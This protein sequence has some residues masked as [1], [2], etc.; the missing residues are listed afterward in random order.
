MGK[1]ILKWLGIALGGVL[2]LILLAFIVSYVAV[3]RFLDKEHD[4][5]SHSIAVPTD[6]ALIAEGERLANFRGCYGACHGDE[7]EGEVM[8]DAPFIARVVVPSLSHL[9]R[10][11]TTAEFERAVRHGVKGDGTSVLIMPSST[12]QHLSDDDLGATIAFLRSLPA[13]DGPLTEVKPR[14]V[15]YFLFAFGLFQGFRAPAEEIDHAAPHTAANPTDTLALGR[16][17]AMSVCSLCHGS[18]LQG[19]EGEKG[20]TPS[21]SI[22]AAYTLDGFTQV[23]REGIGLGGREL[24]EMLEASEGFKHFTDHEIAALYAYLST[25]AQQE[26]V[27]AGTSE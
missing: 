7:A 5:P 1:R 9:A 19:G 26:P 16:Y 23:L 12:F 2:V 3:R 18:D 27:D 13:D 25:L 20:P 10:E 21:L 22:V 8:I 24:D 14:L 17:L 6:S 4:V 11:Y 15:G